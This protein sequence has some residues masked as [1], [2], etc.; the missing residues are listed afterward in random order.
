MTVS[1]PRQELILLALPA[2]A[3][4]EALHAGLDAA[5]LSCRGVDSGEE[6]LARVD[7]A[8]A[9]VLGWTLPDMS[10]LECLRRLRVL[11]SL[12]KV[13][14]VLV[15][16]PGHS[17]HAAMT[18]ALNEGAN[19]CMVA[20]V[21]PALLALRLRTW[22]RLRE[23]RE[24]RE[25]FQRIAGHD[26]R[27]PLTQILATVDV[28][29][30]LV[31][32]GKPMTSDAARLLNAVGDAAR[33]MSRIVDDFLDLHVLQDVSLSLETLPFDIGTLLEAAVLRHRPRA[34]EKGIAI[35][36]TVGCSCRLRIDPDRLEQVLD[37]LLGNAIKFSPCGSLI[38]IRCGRE[39]SGW[40]RVEISDQGPGLSAEDLRRV[41]ERYARLSARPTAGE[42]STG[43][44]LA[45]SREIVLRHGGEIGVHNNVEGPGATFWLRLPASP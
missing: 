34:A 12:D 3:D 1:P 8:S 45:I 10:G 13:P 21:D 18:E 11:H 5:G 16:D 6:A 7:Q 26:L 9:L 31:P 17:E 40:T 42:D 43:L 27:N 15:A 37:N 39:P 32:V 41:F 30:A 28:V 14:T 35:E 44:G 23:L 20:P 2:G 29:S 4:R 24:A 33:R 25:H 22:L 19:D 38:A 36:I